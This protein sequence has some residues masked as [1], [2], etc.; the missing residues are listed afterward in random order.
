M[1][2]LCGTADAVSPQGPVR[3]GDAV[4]SIHVEAGKRNGAVVQIDISGNEGDLRI[5]NPSA[6][7][8][9][10]DDYRIFGT[11]VNAQP[12]VEMPV[13]ASYARIPDSALPS[14]MLELAELYAA[15][16][17]DAATAA[18][19]HPRSRMSSSCIASSVE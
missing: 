8:G 18:A 13:H 6:F 15:Y 14:A 2:A 9:V 1:S 7:G 16:A 10:G 4:V 19:W 17:H 5:F 12:C 11:R 3:L